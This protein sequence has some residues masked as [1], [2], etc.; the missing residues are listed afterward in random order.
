M[1]KERKKHTFIVTSLLA[2]FAAR[3][4]ASPPAGYKLVWAEEFNAVGQKPDPKRWTYD[5]GQTGWGNQELE[6]YADDLEHA[7]IVADADATDGA[8]LQIKATRE[9]SGEYRSARLKTEGRFAP[10]YGFIEARIRRPEGQG[11]W[12]AFWMLGANFAAVSWPACGE[13]DIMESPGKL[14]WSHRSQ[15]VVHDP[16]YYGGEA[17]KAD[18]ILKGKPFSAGYHLFQVKWEKDCLEFFVDGIFYERRT[19]DE[20]GEEN[21][22]FNHPMFLLLNVAVGGGWPGNPDNTTVFPQ[23][24]MVDYIRV[25]QKAD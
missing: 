5:L 25:Y 24:M 22:T 18:F 3:A 4:N 13:V 9:A 11:I 1:K 16:A 12:P 17:L 19:A 2:L 6:N 7:G 15:G 23:Q 21:W 10:Q 20:I 8:A 14:S